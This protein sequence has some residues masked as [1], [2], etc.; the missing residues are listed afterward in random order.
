MP[1]FNY[2]AIKDGKTVSGSTEAKSREAVSALLARENMRPL[3]IK[4]SRTVQSKNFLEKFGGKVKL[5]DL[6]I[7]TRQLSTMINAGY[8]SYAVLVLYRRKPKAK[9]SRKSSPASRTRLKVESA[10]RTH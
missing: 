6:V 7:F 3:L 1:T 5:K 9:D 8:L 10:W 2:T 4:E